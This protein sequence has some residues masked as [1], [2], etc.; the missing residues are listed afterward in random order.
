MHAGGKT[1]LLP[2]FDAE[3]AV[4]HLAEDKA[5]VM[6]EFPPILT[7]CPIKPRPSLDIRSLRV[8]V[9]LDQPETIRRFQRQPERLLG[10]LWTNRDLGLVSLSLI[11]EAWIAGLSVL[12]PKSKSWM[13]TVRFWRW[14]QANRCSRTDGFG[15]WNR[16]E[17]NVH[18]PGGWHHQDL[19][20]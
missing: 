7:T 15:Y 5:T 19:A 13:T 18:L 12:S 16:K 1:I 11:R 9:G 6:G 2:R 10:L 4:K 3:L 17:D 14:K 8:V 20:A